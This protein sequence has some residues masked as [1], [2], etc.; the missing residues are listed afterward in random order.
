[1]RV[2]LIVAVLATVIYPTYPGT[3]IRDYSQPGYQI[4]GNHIQ[5]TYPGTA[6]PNYGTGGYNVERGGLHPTIPGGKMDDF[7]QDTIPFEGN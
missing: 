5:P 6:I 3:T 4:D 1:M 7:M 2:L